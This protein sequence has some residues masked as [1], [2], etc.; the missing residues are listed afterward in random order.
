MSP[1]TLAKPGDIILL[2]GGTY[3]RGGGNTEQDGIVHFEGMGAPAAWI[4]LRI[5]I[6]DAPAF[7]PAEPLLQVGD[8]LGRKRWEVARRDPRKR[9]QRND[10]QSEEGGRQ[11]DGVLEARKKGTRHR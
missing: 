10:D 7:Q 2:M 9:G 6:R 1:D 5:R 3:R 4:V 8:P 11:R